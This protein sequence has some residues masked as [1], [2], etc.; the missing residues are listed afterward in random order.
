MRGTYG[1]LLQNN[2]RNRLNS[3]LSLVL[4]CQIHGPNHL[5]PLQL[6]E[7]EYCI[8]ILCMVPVITLKSTSEFV[9]LVWERRYIPMSPMENWWIPCSRCFAKSHSPRSRNRA[10]RM[11]GIDL[12][13]HEEF[14]HECWSFHANSSISA[15]NFTFTLCRMIVSSQR[16]QR[17][18]KTM[19][20]SANAMDD[21]AQT[22]DSCESML[23]LRDF[24]LLTY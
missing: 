22:W 15:T 4:C 23:M 11:Q 18:G 24:W 14:A 9:Q 2:I 5:G 3:I 19:W 8:G 7:I 12:H 10:M 17:W 20:K 13:V 6:M 21:Q 16:C 1:Q